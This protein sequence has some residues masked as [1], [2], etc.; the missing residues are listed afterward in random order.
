MW[1]GPANERG[2]S[3]SSLPI[4]A[5]VSRHTGTRSAVRTPP[6]TTSRLRTTARRRVSRS[7]NHAPA[8]R[9]RPADGRYSARSARST[10]TGTTRFETGK[11]AI[12]IQPSPRSEEHTSELQSPMYLVCRLLLEKKNKLD[13]FCHVEQE[14]DEV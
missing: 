13:Y 1:A 5:R 10:P 3:S 11:S 7:F 14:I 9:T 8:A 4:M 2:E 12:A 6:A